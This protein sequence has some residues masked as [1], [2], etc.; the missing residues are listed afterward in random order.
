MAYKT[1]VSRGPMVVSILVD[2]IQMPVYEHDG[3]L[4]VEVKPEASVTINVF[5][6]H[7]DNERIEVLMGV[8]GR[9]VL[10]DEPATLQMGGMVIRHG[11]TWE[12]RGW[13]ID[14]KRVREFV[15]TQQVLDA[16]AVQATGSVARLGVIGVACYEE[17]VMRYSG[18][19]PEVFRGMTPKGGRSADGGMGMGDEVEDRV[20]RTKFDRLTK[21][22]RAVVE[23][24]YRT[25]PTLIAM[26][27][28][29]FG[30]DETDY[31]PAF[32]DS[33]YG[34]FRPVK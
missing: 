10:V 2:G 8:D 7:I 13:R 6:R 20:G 17:K 22:P 5:N 19:S 4:F 28:V 11:Q 25:R 16:V 24:H 14:D 23:I 12:S 18:G 1:Q 29:V 3:R 30:A 15:F 31:P 21:D 26:G 27:I 33:G 34:K 32:G 9:N